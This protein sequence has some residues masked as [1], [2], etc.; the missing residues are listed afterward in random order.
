MLFMQARPAYYLR[1]T[2]GMAVQNITDMQ[3][4]MGKTAGEITAPTDTIA[5]NDVGAIG[6]FSGRYVV[7]LIGLVTPMKTFGENLRDHRPMLLAIFDPW[8]PERRTDSTFVNH[9]RYLAALKLNQ[10]I[11]C[12]YEIMSLY[13]RDDRFEDVAARFHELQMSSE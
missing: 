10:N 2:H 5:T 1:W 11:V 3:I 7:D 8:F 6:Y 12:G 4:T 9:Y 13:V